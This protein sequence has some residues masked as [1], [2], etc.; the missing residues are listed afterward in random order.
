MRRLPNGELDA[1]TGVGQGMLELN[2]AANKQ[3]PDHLHRELQLEVAKT[4]IDLIIRKEISCGEMSESEARSLFHGVAAIST[5]F[6]KW[7]ATVDPYYVVGILFGVERPLD[8]KVWD[9]WFTDVGD[10]LRTDRTSSPILE[11]HKL[12]MKIAEARK[13]M[14]NQYRQQRAST[15]KPY[16]PAWLEEDFHERKRILDL[17][18]SIDPRASSVRDLLDRQLDVASQATARYW[19]GMKVDDTDLANYEALLRQSSQYYLQRERFG[20]LFNDLNLIIGVVIARLEGYKSVTTASVFQDFQEADNAFHRL[21]GQAYLLQALEKLTAAVAT[22]DK[23]T[24]N[25]LY[26]RGVNVS[27]W[28]VRDWYGRQG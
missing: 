23:L 19:A 12:L 17:T 1:T 9:L 8:A 15:G 10:W 6:D 14:W 4:M 26:E 7:I 20:S 16:A 24:V 3:G 5:P 11:R 22:V 27:I 13:Y 25:N 18:L 2:V 21:S 28:A